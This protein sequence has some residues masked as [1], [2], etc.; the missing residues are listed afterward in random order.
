[1][2]SNKR[3]IALAAFALTLVLT[4]GFSSAYAYSGGYGFKGKSFS[5]EKYQDMT[6]KRETMNEIYK[7]NDYNA[8]KQIME[9]KVGEMGK[10]ISEENF[11]QMAKIHSLMQQGEYEKAREL[12]EGLKFGLTGLKKGQ[13]RNHQFN[14]N[15]IE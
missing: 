12:K 13:F 8:W 9:E 14:C 1:M 7:N 4:A 2:T 15:T 3:I 10:Q 11:S 5:P 6:E